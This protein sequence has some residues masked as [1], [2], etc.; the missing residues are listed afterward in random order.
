MSVSVL[1]KPTCFH[2]PVKVVFLD[3]NQAFLNALSM[4]FGQK[5]NFVMLTSP[6]E[7]MCLINQT[8]E[9]AV[10]SGMLMNKSNMDD[11]RS[12]LLDLI[13]DK[14]RFNQ[15]AVLVVDYEMP[16][17]N[18]VEFCE[19]LKDK[20]LFKI[21]LTAEADKD[22]AINA[23]NNGTID[24]YILKTTHNLH[25]EILSSIDELTDRYFNERSKIPLKINGDSLERLLSDEHYKKVFH[26]IKTSNDALEYYLVDSVGSFLFLSKNAKPTWLIVCDQ[27]KAHEQAELLMGYSFSSDSIQSIKSQESILFLLS[28]SEYKEPASQWSKYIFEA[29]KLNEGY[30]YSVV[31][32]VLTGSICW[33]EVG[34]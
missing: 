28:D 12:G 18:G 2:H 30:S 4:E 33:G 9:G 13:Y 1:A 19:K 21:L 6:D 11:S 20:T 34:G 7:V 31:H 23:F 32:G 25:A 29:K 10:E 17:I 5:E 15:V 14:S 26:D 16:T 3:D 24:K 22:I 8:T 27:S